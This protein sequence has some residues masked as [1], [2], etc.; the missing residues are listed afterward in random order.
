MSEVIETVALTMPNQ[1]KL[2][3]FDSLSA[4]EQQE[5]LEQVTHMQSTVAD[6]SLRSNEGYD[7]LLAL[8]RS[9]AEVLL[10]TS[11]F[12][13][14]VS[15]N[16]QRI[17]D[18]INDPTA[19][20]RSFVTLLADIK[21]YRDDLDTLYQCH[22]DKKGAPTEEEINDVFA[23]ADGYNKLLTRYETAI[24]P[25]MEALRD[26]ILAECEDLLEAANDE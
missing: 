15:Q 9:N 3:R 14:P 13:V 11:H 12:V 5:V 10:L 20:K 1:D 22:K 7:I 2:E 18:D 16:L 4:T 17:C 24:Q 23:L 8:Y 25:L 6:A 19:F 21:Q 26:T